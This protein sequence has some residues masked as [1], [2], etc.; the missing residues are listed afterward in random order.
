MGFFKN[1]SHWI[2]GIKVKRLSVPTLLPASCPYKEPLI[3]QPPG[4][5][6][7][8]AIISISKKGYSL[9]ASHSAPKR[10]VQD[11]TFF[12]SLLP[13]DK[14]AGQDDTADDGTLRI[15][16]SCKG[17]KRDDAAPRVT[18][19][20]L[21]RDI[22]R[23]NSATL[24]AP[25]P[26]SE[27]GAGRNQNSLLQPTAWRCRPTGVKSGHTLE[28]VQVKAA[29]LTLDARGRCGRAERNENFPT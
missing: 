19:A 4:G 29:R 12:F 27:Q 1:S 11:A 6:K 20:G 16:V 24:S 26:L 3:P 15:F 5:Q 18:R 22:W 25:P 28:S 21:P 2:T 23:R 13:T 9:S 17:R 10:C 14:A 7:K 8:L